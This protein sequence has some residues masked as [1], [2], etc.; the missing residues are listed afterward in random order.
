MNEIITQVEDEVAE[1]YMLFN[2][3]VVKRWDST[4]GVWVD[5]TTS[6]SLLSNPGFRDLSVMP[7]GE[8]YV[9]QL[10]NRFHWDGI[11]WMQVTG[12]RV[13]QPVGV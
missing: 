8:L 4:Q 10:D 1:H 3:S 9:T 11:E 13:P 7:G 5:T 2:E 6:D 12:V